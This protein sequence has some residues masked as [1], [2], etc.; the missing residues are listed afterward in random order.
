MRSG[1]GL[2]GHEMWSDERHDN[3]L[4]NAVTRIDNESFTGI[5]VDEGDANL[6]TIRSVDRSR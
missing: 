5:E 2:H 6:A 4:R 1:E 3:Q